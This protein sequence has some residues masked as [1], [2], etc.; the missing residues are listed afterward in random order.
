MKLAA[1][2]KSNF[3]RRLIEVAAI[4]TRRNLYNCRLKATVGNLD[5][6]L[7]CFVQDPL[8]NNLT[9]IGSIDFNGGIG[10]TPQR[11]RD[12]HGFRQR[13]TITSSTGIAPTRA[14]SS[15]GGRSPA[16]TAT[17]RKRCAQKKNSIFI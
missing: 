3:T 14:A 7:A 12:S 4:F 2:S 16:A 9:I 5:S 17:G 11:S 1:L 15:S 6:G 10:D 8:T 13:T